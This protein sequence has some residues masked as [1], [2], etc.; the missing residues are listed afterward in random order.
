MHV[1]IC[2]AKVRFW[3]D[4]CSTAPIGDDM[5]R[6]ISSLS[7]AVDAFVFIYDKSKVLDLFSPNQH[8]H[9]HYCSTNSINQKPSTFH[10][11]AQWQPF[12][13]AAAPNI[14]LCLAV[15]PS[16]PPGA[17]DQHCFEPADDHMD[18][19]SDCEPFEQIIHV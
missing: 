2:S 15:S 16:I 17:Q 5:G 4:G 9:H 7:D 10:S 8:P 18:W 1:C 11:L 14:Q 19:V 12:L 13:D 6:W 3:I